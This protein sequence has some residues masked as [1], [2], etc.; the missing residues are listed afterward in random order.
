MITTSAP[1]G[2]AQLAERRRAPPGL[3]ARLL[4]RTGAK[5]PVARAA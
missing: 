4:R 3:A 1:A 2:R 5:M